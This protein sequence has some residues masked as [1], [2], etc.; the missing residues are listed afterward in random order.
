MMNAIPAQAGETGVLHNTTFPKGPLL[1][2]LLMANTMPIPHR[3][4]SR[5]RS[6]SRSSTSLRF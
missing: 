3:Y 2:L 4:F 6:V 1:R 5:I